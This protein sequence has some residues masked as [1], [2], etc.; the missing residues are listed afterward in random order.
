[1]SI[2]A[3]FGACRQHDP[4]DAV[5]EDVLGLEPDLAIDL[6]VRHS[7]DLLHP[8]VAHAAPGGE[9]RQPALIINPSAQDAPP[10]RY[11]HLI[12]PLAEGPCAF[13]AGG[14]G[15]HDQDGIVGGPRWNELGMPPLAPFLAHGRVLG[16]AHGHHGEVGGNADIAADAF[17]DVVD[18][19]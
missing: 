16:A 4:R 8:M 7:L 2:P 6:D 14:P 3:P 18:A 5:V 11:R 1:D 9:A 19:A 17:P 15:A 12:S 13:E 10:V